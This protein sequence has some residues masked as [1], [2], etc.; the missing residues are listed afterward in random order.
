M[1]T[2]LDN[3]L[4]CLS[5][6]GYSVFSLINDILSHCSDWEDR[7]IKSLREGV[8]RDSM[9]ICARILNHKPASASMSDL[10]EGNGEEHGFHLM[11]SY[12]LSLPNHG[13]IPP[14]LSFGSA[15]K[16]TNL[17][18]ELFIIGSARCTCSSSVVPPGST[19]L[20]LRAVVK[21]R[22]TAI[23][24]P[25]P[26]DVLLEIFDLC[27]QDPTDY[28]IQR[29]RKWL[30]LA[31]VCQ[32][33]RRIIFASPRRLNLSLI[34]TYGTPV[35]RNLVYWP[36]TFPLT[37]DYSKASCRSDPTPY[38]NNN[39]V[40]ALTH[41]DRIHRV[42]I[43]AANSVLSKV[44]DVMQETFPAL[45]YLRLEWDFRGPHDAL[46]VLPEGLLGGSAQRLQ[47]LHLGGVT[48]PGLPTLLS[49]AS[50]LTTLNL[51]S[52]TQDTFISPEAMVASLA[53]LTKLRTFFIAFIEVGPQPDQWRSPSDP[54]NRAVLPALTHF[55]YDGHDEYLE[56][57][58]A[59]I[60]TPLVYN[61][62][63]HFNERRREF[64]IPQFSRFI[65]HTENLKL[66]QFIRAHVAFY[67]TVEVDLGEFPQ[68]E[69]TLAFSGFYTSNVVHVLGQL[70]AMFSNVNQLS[71]SGGRVSSHDMESTGWLLFLRL[72]PAVEVLEVYGDVIQ[73]IASALEDTN[74]D[75]D[76]ELLPALSSLRFDPCDSEKYEKS[77][78]SM[79]KFFSL[80]PV[81]VTNI[82]YYRS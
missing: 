55:H 51:D 46:F 32:R 21:Y 43:D 62:K 38:D 56:D 54:P 6:N 29:M 11:T 19:D 22:R 2:E 72:F 75:M 58:L 71:V 25:L 33:W 60:D 81:T 26:D 59:L 10:E 57:L 27:L 41:A 15:S 52:I 34:C 45:T 78:G 73:D 37:V 61:V 50:N 82:V 20:Q 35:R 36:L 74:D 63:I 17:P 80:R 79:E 40:A 28:T 69:V 76:A 53:V 49:S 5:L 3:V 8:E 24:D 70:D 18:E 31:H 9:K 14:G 77:M 47:Y 30:K 68:A 23:I 13:V 39:M 1:R 67:S 66:A 64:Q 42:S 48:F 44:A 16:P 7:R 65:G 12:P 4:Q